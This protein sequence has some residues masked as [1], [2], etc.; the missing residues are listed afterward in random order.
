MAT[1]CVDFKIIAW[2]YTTQMNLKISTE[3]EFV[4][5]SQRPEDEKSWP[6]HKEGEDVASRGISSSREGSLRHKE[7][8]RVCGDV[9]WSA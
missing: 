7:K 1:E 6:R 5:M 2:I 4:E 3:E 9:A 8:Q